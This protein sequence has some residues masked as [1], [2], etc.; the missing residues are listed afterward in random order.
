MENICTY[1][2]ITVKKRTILNCSMNAHRIRLRRDK[3]RTNKIFYLR[4]HCHQWNEIGKCEIKNTL[5][6]VQQK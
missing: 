4:S 6:D 1:T 5:K 2:E 3:K